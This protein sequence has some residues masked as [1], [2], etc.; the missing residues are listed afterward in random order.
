[1][2]RA[3]TR[4][5]AHLLRSRNVPGPR[6]QAC[7]GLEAGKIVMGRQFLPWGDIHK[8]IFGIPART[9][10]APCRP[11]GREE[12]HVLRR[13]VEGAGHG[14]ASGRGIDLGRALLAFAAIGAGAESPA[15]A[16]WRSDSIHGACVRQVIAA[17][18][19]AGG[20]ARAA[21]PALLLPVPYPSAAA[22]GRR[23]PCR[24][25]AGQCLVA[26]SEDGRMGVLTHVMWTLPYR[27]LIDVMPGRRPFRAPGGVAPSRPRLVTDAP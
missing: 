8:T 24:W 13:A 27:V 21:T 6:R 2:D 7:E 22:L 20:P 16:C 12:R 9:P 1:M 23:Q 26:V 18:G 4:S 19:L 3:M 11:P 10:G 14:Q 17:T 5:P 25:A 15:Q